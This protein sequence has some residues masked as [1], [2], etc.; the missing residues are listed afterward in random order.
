MAIIE[1]ADYQSV[2]R[3][4]DSTLDDVATSDSDRILPDAMIASYVPIA[5]RETISLYAAAATYPGTLTDDQ[6]FRI[7]E[8]TVRFLAAA[9]Y[10]SIPRIIME[11]FGDHRYRREYES[12]DDVINRLRDEAMSLLNPII[13]S[14]GETGRTKRFRRATATRGRML[15]TT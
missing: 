12:T 10:P 6:K 2:R 7:K 14:T 13:L 11:A 5:E 1:E 4:I 8:A 15:T 9:L 3:V